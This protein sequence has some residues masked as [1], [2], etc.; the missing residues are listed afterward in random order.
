L[1]TWKEPGVI[2]VV[3]A[4]GAK[5]KLDFNEVDGEKGYVPRS[6]TPPPPPSSREQK[7]S[8][9]HVTPKKDK[10]TIVL[11]GSAEECHQAQ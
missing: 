2:G 10:G 3:D 8:K 6:G 4:G 7:R 11:A 9:K 1:L 5:K